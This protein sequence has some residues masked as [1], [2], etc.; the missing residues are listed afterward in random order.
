[1]GGRTP[2]VKCAFTLCYIAYG[3]CTPAFL[4][5]HTFVLHARVNIQFN[6][7]NSIGIIHQSCQ[8]Q[9]IDHQL[10][11]LTQ[12]QANPPISR[13]ENHKLP[14]FI[15]FSHS[16]LFPHLPLALLGAPGGLTQIYLIN[17]LTLANHQ[18]SCLSNPT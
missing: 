14:L 16:N 4:S 11:I 5:T 7:N 9:R 1:M 10:C 8:V 12:S 13:V 2:F 17:T 18:S 6:K 15:F 3:I